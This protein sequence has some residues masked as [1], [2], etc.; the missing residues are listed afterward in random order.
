M[1]ATE[2][3]HD[4]LGHRIYFLPSFFYS[5]TTRKFD[6][7]VPV[8][9]DPAFVITVKKKA[10]YFFKLI[11]PDINLVIETKARNGHFH[12]INCIE[13]PTVGYIS[14]LLEKGGLISFSYF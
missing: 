2:P 1:K 4:P 6:E 9:T 11:D 14:S 13:N 5:K 7:L 8:I 12:A 3:V 10:L